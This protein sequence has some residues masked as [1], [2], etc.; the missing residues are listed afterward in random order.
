MYS[1]NNFTTQS[2]RSLHVQSTHGTGS[3]A[4]GGGGLQP[5]TRKP[6]KPEKP[7][8]T[9]PRADRDDRGLGSPE[10]GSRGPPSC[11]LVLPPLKPLIGTRSEGGGQLK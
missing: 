3:A 9:L 2:L 8:K 7:R 5:L 4:R 10:I 11:R 1:T 6:E